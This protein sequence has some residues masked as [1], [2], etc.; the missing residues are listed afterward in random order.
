[1]RLLVLFPYGHC[2]SRGHGGNERIDYRRPGVGRVVWHAAT[3][4]SLLH[5]FRGK[6]KHVVCR[7][8]STA[9]IPNF[10]Y[11]IATRKLGSEQSW[12]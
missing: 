6:A 2:V 7:V 10:D 5:M 3:P 9:H 4:N 8:G 11:K 12:L 1:V